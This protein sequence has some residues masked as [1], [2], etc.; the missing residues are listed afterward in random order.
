MFL[1]TLRNGKRDNYQS[2]TRRALSRTLLTW[3]EPVSL[4]MNTRRRKRK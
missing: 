4:E 3:N 1:V 2:I